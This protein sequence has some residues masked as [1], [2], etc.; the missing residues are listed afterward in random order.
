MYLGIFLV[1]GVGQNS[2]LIFWNDIVIC[3]L[4]EDEN[5]LK[6][7]DMFDYKIFYVIK[8]FS[9]KDEEEFFYFI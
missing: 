8:V 7:I 2:L 4:K 3:N 6:V 5:F 1:G 9:E